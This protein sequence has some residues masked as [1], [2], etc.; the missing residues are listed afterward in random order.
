MAKAESP[1]ISIF[2][3]TF[4]LL[5]LTH[6]GNMEVMRNQRTWCVA[7]PS[8]DEATLLNI[9]QYA[10]SMTGC[11]SLQKNS[12]CF[13]PDNLISHASFAM[14]LYYH[15]MGRNSWNCHFNGTGLIVITDPSYG[16]CRYE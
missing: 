15:A 11:K 9:L 7:K 3:L 5:L 14:N 8:A 13:I 1:I 10:C 12:P 2:S 6:G 4:F 16:R